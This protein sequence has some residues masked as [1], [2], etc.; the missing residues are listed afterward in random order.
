MIAGFAVAVAAA[1]AAA[2]AD[3]GAAADA[4]AAAIHR[5]VCTSS[6]QGCTG[7]WSLH[8]QQLGVRVMLPLRRQWTALGHPSMHSCCG[9]SCVDTQ[10]S[11]SSTGGCS[12]SIGY[13]FDDVPWS[14]FAWVSSKR[15]RR[16]LEQ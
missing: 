16:T 14:C 12:S 3:E 5:G 9:R 15:S 13:V 11:G 2:A 7:S 6:S 1:D 4:A 8:Q 10:C